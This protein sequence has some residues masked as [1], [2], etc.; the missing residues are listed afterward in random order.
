MLMVDLK[1]AKSPTDAAV[2]YFS[3]RKHRHSIIQ[4]CSRKQK[5][6][7]M[8][9]AALPHWQYLGSA[10][11]RTLTRRLGFTRLRASAAA[12]PATPAPMIATSMSGGPRE[13][14]AVSALRYTL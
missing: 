9:V 10:L 8:Q 5:H 11:L 13:G 12:S 1:P 7:R 4:D 14:P 6:I 2:H 3:G